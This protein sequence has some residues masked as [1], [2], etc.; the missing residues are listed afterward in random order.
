[1]VERSVNQP[2]QAK[3]EM[4]RP[5]RITSLAKDMVRDLL[6][7]QLAPWVLYHN[8]QHTVE[9][10]RAAMAIGK[11]S[12]LSPSEL[13]MLQLAAWFHDTGFVKSAA[14]HERI[15]ANIAADFLRAHHY[16]ERNLAKVVQ[17]ILSTK[18]P[19]SPRTKLQRILCDADHASLGK[20][21]FFRQNEALRLETEARKRRSIDQLPWLRR[22]LHFLEHTR[23]VSR[24]ARMVYGKQRE[25]NLHR[26]RRIVRELELQYLRAAGR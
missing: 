12:R 24:S 20:R 15:S 18:M 8:Y 6:E 23:F 10:V 11:R 25:A 19:R 16:P 3:R 2:E 14:G 9:T 26:L 5:K 21:S 4:A 1:M 13:E 17:G 7:E 22:T